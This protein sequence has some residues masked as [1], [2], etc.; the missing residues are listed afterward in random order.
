MKIPHPT[1]FCYNP[2]QLKTIVL[3]ADPSNFSDNGNR[4]ILTKAGKHTNTKHTISK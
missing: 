2:K 4:K 1:P 3:G